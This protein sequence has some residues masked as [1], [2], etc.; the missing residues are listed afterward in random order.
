MF[1]LEVVRE[2]CPFGGV[3]MEISFI[4]DPTTWWDQPQ[5]GY[6]MI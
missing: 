2:F 5:Q 6:R 3:V 4:H 1:V